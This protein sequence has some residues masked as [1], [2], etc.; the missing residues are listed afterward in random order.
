MKKTKKPRK[1]TRHHKRKTRYS[2]KSKR[3]FRL[4]T[5]KGG[6]PSDT[7]LLFVINCV[8]RYN[9]LT[10]YFSEV[11]LD[12]MEE[13][14]YIRGNHQEFGIWARF[15]ELFENQDDMLTLFRDMRKELEK[16]NFGFLFHKTEE[17]TPE[18]AVS[19]AQN[20]NDQFQRIQS[21]GVVPINETVQIESLFGDPKATPQ[22]N[23]YSGEMKKYCKIL[24]EAEDLFLE[25]QQQ[26]TDEIPRLPSKNR[27]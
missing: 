22:N 23:L 12:T 15:K 21:P 16:Y 8:S 3:N 13:Y 27:V 24:K 26:N 20:I 2:R 1:T 9:R 4:R 19:I 7:Y 17:Y 5:Q 14:I 11:R 25:V 6:G 18:D 10:Q